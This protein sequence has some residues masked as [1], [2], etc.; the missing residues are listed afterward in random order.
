MTASRTWLIGS[1]PACDIV[2]PRPNISRQH[3]RLT[4][5]EGRL[6]LKDLRSTNGTYVNGQ[7]VA[8]SVEITPNDEIVLASDIEF[9]WPD[10]IGEA[11]ED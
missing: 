10:E 4:M 3:C 7:A 5:E 2:I 6:V 1:S 9:P 11:D 8:G